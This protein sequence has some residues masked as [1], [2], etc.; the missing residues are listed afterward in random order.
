MRALVKLFVSE[1]QT[2]LGLRVLFGTEDGLLGDG[3]L[4]RT[5]NGS[6]ADSHWQQVEFCVGLGLWL[7][8][9]PQTPYVA[10]SGPRTVYS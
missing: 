3:I 2:Q 5:T 4:I 8:N 6:V 9:C 10:L 1:I 7:G